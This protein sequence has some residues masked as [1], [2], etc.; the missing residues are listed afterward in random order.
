V[1][2]FPFSV[3]RL[4]GSFHN[5]LLPKYSPIKL[6]VKQIKQHIKTKK[7]YARIKKGRKVMK[8]G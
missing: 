6:F 8:Y 1:L 2:I 7:A 5:S 3:A 4:I